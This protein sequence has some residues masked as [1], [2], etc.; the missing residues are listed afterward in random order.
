MSYPPPIPPPYLPPPYTPLEV[1]SLAIP[2]NN[3]CD[4][5]SV[6]KFQLDLDLITFSKGKSNF[7]FLIRFYCVEVLSVVG[8]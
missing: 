7:S 6:Q 1:G 3:E 8:I 2:A 5:L 4:W